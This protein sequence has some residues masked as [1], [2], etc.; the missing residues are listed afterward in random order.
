MENSVQ[1]PMQQL[2][3]HT[4]VPSGIRW[5]Q[6]CVKCNPRAESR[7]LC[8]PPVGSSANAA[9]RRFVPHSI[10][11]PQAAV[12]ITHAG[13][14][15]VTA[16]LAHGV[17]L[18][19]LPNPM[20]DQPYLARRVEELGVGLAPDGDA[21]PHAI[22]HAVAEVVA[23]DAYRDAAAHL[24]KAIRASSGAS[25]AAHLLEKQAASATK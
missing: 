4:A 7:R 10:V 23:N 18:V 21:P 11:L 14:G 22:R 19:C 15:T 17:P 24:A 13:H 20:A 1:Q 9:V 8:K 12:T 2:G 6:A 16:S 5:V 25:G 3:R